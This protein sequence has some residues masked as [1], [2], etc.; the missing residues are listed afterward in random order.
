MEPPSSPVSGYSKTFALLIPDADSLALSSE[1]STHLLDIM[2]MT[3]TS[4][5]VWL[6]RYSE[7]SPMNLSPFRTETMT[8][9][10]GRSSDG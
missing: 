7:M 4:S 6:T 10:S 8:L 5:N 2:K 1:A 3:S 9:T